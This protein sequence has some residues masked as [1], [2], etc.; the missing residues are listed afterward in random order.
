MDGKI[1]DKI[2][3]LMTLAADVRGNTFERKKAQEKAEELLR[4]YKN[5]EISSCEI[6]FETYTEEEKQTIFREFWV[7][8]IIQNPSTASE[9]PCWGEFTSWEFAYILE[10]HPKFSYLC[11]HFDSFDNSQWRF[12]L[13]SQPSLAVFLK[14]WFIFNLHDW[15]RLIRAH[16]EWQPLYDLYKPQ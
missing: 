4:K 3:K 14:S 9:C 13:I 10:K 2:R 11:K 15:N 1:Y 12:I 6:E 5:N 7:S 8:K 16:P